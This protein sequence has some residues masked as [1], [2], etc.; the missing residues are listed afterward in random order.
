MIYTILTS[1]NTKTVFKV[2]ENWAKPET[3]EVRLIDSRLTE[4]NGGLEVREMTVE[5][6]RQL[7]RETLAAAPAEL[8]AVAKKFKVGDKVAVRNVGVAYVREV[9]TVPNGRGYTLFFVA[10]KGLGKC[11]GGWNDSM[12]IWKVA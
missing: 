4:D 5:A 7:Y 11:G 6:A 2:G 10:G 12:D 1:R 9:D 3:A 8:Q